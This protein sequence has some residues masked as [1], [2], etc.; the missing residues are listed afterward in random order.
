[1]KH[2]TMISGSQGCDFDAKAVSSIPTRENELLVLNIF[3]FSPWHQGKTATRLNTMP[4]LHAM[5]QKN[6]RKVGNEV[7]SH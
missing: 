3:I 4:G 6:R 1:M 2:H 5:P 7:F